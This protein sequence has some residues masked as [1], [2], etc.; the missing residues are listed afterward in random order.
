[1][2][3][4]KVAEAKVVKVKADKAKKTKEELRRVHFAFRVYRFWNGRR[5]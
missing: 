5:K 1:V 2:R 4:Y 3:K